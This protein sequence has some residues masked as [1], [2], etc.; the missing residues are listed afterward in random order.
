V[1]VTLCCCLPFGIVA[2]IYAAQVNGKLA[3]GDIAGAREASKNA[4]TWCWVA[5]G[6]GVVAVA[7]YFMTA[8]LGALHS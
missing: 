8:G 4:R 3:A 7:I 2:I 5:L 6:C 1:L